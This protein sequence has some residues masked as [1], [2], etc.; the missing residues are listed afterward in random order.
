MRQ[1]LDEIKERYAPKVYKHLYSSSLGGAFGEGWRKDCAPRAL[2]YAFVIS[3][4]IV[5]ITIT[6][7]LACWAYWASQMDNTAIFVTIGISSALLMLSVYHAI[8]VARGPKALDGFNGVVFIITIF[9]T[10]FIELP[11][12]TLVSNVYEKFTG[13]CQWR[14]LTLNR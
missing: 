7:L 9:T 4:A 6:I 12:L 3:Y 2:F 8:G 11:L 14:D 10:I 1:R 13:R 5:W